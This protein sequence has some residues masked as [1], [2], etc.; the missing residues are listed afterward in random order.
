H[1]L[2]SRP[3]LPRAQETDLSVL[4]RHAYH[5]VR[6]RSFVF[7]VSDFISAPGWSRALLQLSQRH[8][9]VAVRLFDPLEVELPDPGLI[10]MQDA[11]TGEQL[12]VDTHDAG[13]RERF[14]AA[15]RQRESALRAALQQAGVDTL[16][17]STGDDLVDAIVR[18]AD[19]RKH[20]RQLAAAGG[21]P[22]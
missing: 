4:L 11:E 22:A 7:I 5:V 8:E 19:L 1:A 6:S 13:F 14:A 18:F 3:E 20:R 17:L 16:E 9:I 12:L 21:L 2:Q 10:V 15:A